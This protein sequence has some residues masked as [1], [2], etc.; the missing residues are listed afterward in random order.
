MGRALKI[1][2]EDKDIILGMI[3]GRYSDG[4][5]S[6]QGDG[7]ALFEEL[8]KERY[9]KPTSRTRGTFDRH[10]KALME[11]QQELKVSVITPTCLTPV[12]V[13]GG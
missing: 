13:Y 2:R 11:Q 8:H 6:T 3:T 9:G 10:Y 5:P 1:G 7:Y 12:H 4:K